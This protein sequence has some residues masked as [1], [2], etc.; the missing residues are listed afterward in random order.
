MGE[1]LLFAW[2]SYNGGCGWRDFVGRFVSLEAAQAHFAT[3][4]AD[5]AHI[6]RDDDIVSEWQDSWPNETSEWGP[7][8]PFD[9]ARRLEWR[10]G[11]LS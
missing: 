11:P 4:E 5:N 6:V 3:L 1:Y 9:R 8:D 7:E 2:E 10:T